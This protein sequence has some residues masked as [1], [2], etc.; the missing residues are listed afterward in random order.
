MAI[1]RLNGSNDVSVTDL[2]TFLS[3]NKAETFLADATIEESTTKFS[4]GNAHYGNMLKITKGNTVLEVGYCSATD[5]GTYGPFPMVRLST[6]SPAEAIKTIS[7][8][9]ASD[10]ANCGFLRGSVILCSHGILFT[11]KTT[12][13]YG[14]TT[15]STGDVVPF[16][17]FD[18]G[19]GGIGLIGGN[20]VG[21][22]SGTVDIPTSI[23]YITDGSYNAAFTLTPYYNIQAT[24]I[25][26]VT[27]VSA[28]DFAVSNY[29][30]I[31]LQTQWVSGTDTADSVHGNGSDYI[32][33]GKIYI[34]D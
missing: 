1:Y 22:V 32:A 31:A 21:K 5:S 17:V 34:K 2:V 16:G 10:V 15:T 28:S 7:M 27:F 26:P 33:N 12:H 25:V 29:L 20:I 24:N 30:H 11:E 3:A 4:A 8:T 9:H 6:V 13:Y 19:N 23:S 14:G 18:D